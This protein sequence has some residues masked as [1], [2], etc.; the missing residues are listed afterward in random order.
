MGASFLAVAKSIYYSR[1]TCQRTQNGNGNRFHDNGISSHLNTVSY[2]RD[3]GKCKTKSDH[4]IS[5]LNP[6]IHCQVLFLL[7]STDLCLRR[8]ENTR[9]TNANIFLQD[10]PSTFTPDSGF[11]GGGL[12]QN[13]PSA[14]CCCCCYFFFFI[15]M[16]IGQNI[17]AYFLQH[18]GIKRHTLYHLRTTY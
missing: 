5:C 15:P 1:H 17:L 16:S 7:Q 3:F 13:Q 12:K 14:F 4:R 6:S 18:Q 8:R 9:K 10:Q 2:L 11:S